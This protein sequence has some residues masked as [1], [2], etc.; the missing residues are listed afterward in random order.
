MMTSEAD[1]RVGG[2][3][4]ARRARLRD[5]V[6]LVLLPTTLPGLFK[7]SSTSFVLYLGHGRLRNVPKACTASIELF[8]AIWAFIMDA[9]H[10]IVSRRASAALPALMLMVEG[11]ERWLV[12]A[13]LTALE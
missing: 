6:L 3:L 9:R 10:R 5:V 7:S 12:S 11:P 2:R 4:S 1:V 13:A 8:A